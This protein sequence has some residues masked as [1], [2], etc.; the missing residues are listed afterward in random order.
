L[1]VKN[2]S[3]FYWDNAQYQPVNL[4]YRLLDANDKVVVSDGLRTSLPFGV[5]SGETVALSALVK[6]PSQAGKYRLLLTM[7]QENVA[8]F[9]DQ[10]APSAQVDLEVTN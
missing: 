3:N 9:A 4:S 1:T 10:K 8:W 2:T 6:T 5:A 7:V